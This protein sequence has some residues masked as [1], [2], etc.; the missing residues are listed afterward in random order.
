MVNLPSPTLTVTLSHPH[1]HPLPPSLLPS[2]TLTVNSPTFNHPL[3]PSLSTSPTLT[4]NLPLNV[5]LSHQMLKRQS[6]LGSSEEEM[7]KCSNLADYHTAQLADLR[8]K[9]RQATVAAKQAL[10]KQMREEL[11]SGNREGLVGR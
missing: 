1:C 4:V 7:T 8:L 5:T 11:L 9:I 6:R 10:E 3:P 2:P